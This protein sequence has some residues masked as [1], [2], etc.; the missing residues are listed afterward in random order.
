V[1]LDLP[2]VQ[3]PINQIMKTVNDHNMHHIEIL[4]DLASHSL[5]DPSRME[6]PRRSPASALVRLCGWRQAPS[7]SRDKEA[8]VQ[9]DRLSEEDGIDAAKSPLRIR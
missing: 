3:F 5:H 7:I 6:Q 4:L 2:S 1:S 8:K 9:G